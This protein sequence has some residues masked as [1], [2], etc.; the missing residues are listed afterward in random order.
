ML[1]PMI[2]L[3][4]EIRRSALLSASIRNAPSL[5]L[6]PVE[7][8]ARPPLEPCFTLGESLR[9]RI[10]REKQLG[11]DDTIAI[12]QNV[13]GAEALRAVPSICH[14]AEVQEARPYRPLT[15]QRATVVTYVETV[16]WGTALMGRGVSPVRHP[17]ADG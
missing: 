13:A 7:R 8:P 14:H 10:D 3:M 6:W 15:R 16:G 9:D 4:E 2:S 17:Q 1:S 12:T 11:G 5:T